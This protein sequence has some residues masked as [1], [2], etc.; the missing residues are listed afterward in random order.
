M[1]DFLTEYKKLQLQTPRL[2]SFRMNDIN[3][4]YTYNVKDAKNCYLIANAVDNENCMYGRDFYGNHD[5]IDC[6][7]ILSCT[8]CYQCL[9]CENC[10]NCEF[11]QDSHNS[12]DC[13]YGYFLKGCKNCVGCVGLK[14]KSFH[15]FNEPY[16]EEEYHKKASSLTRD[17]TV[18]RLETLKLEIPRVWAMEVDSE[19]FTGNEVFHSKNVFESFDVNECQDSGYLLECKKVTDSWDITIL[20][21]GELCYQLSSC[22]I[23]S[24]CNFC[25]FC[26]DCHDVEYGEGLMACQNCFGC[27]SLH[28]KRYYILNEP[29]GADEYFK[30]VAELKDQLRS[31][32]LYG[33]MIIPPVFPREDTVAVWDRM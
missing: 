31:Q 10:Y 5:C 19:N 16:S 7:H 30:K 11:L 29:Y 18:K 24:N 21:E 32:G 22:H 4:D 25:F 14:Q 17:E 8:L 15:I 2:S 9:S 27:I 20:E 13:R 28:R 26:V 33:K 23:M 3:S 12:S 1:I 6:D